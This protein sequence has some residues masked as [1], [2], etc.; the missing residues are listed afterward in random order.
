MTKEERELAKQL[1]EEHLKTFLKKP[2]SK[3][4]YDE[5]CEV[6][7]GIDALKGNKEI[8]LI[9]YR[10]TFYVSLSDMVAEYR[11]AGGIKRLIDKG[12]LQIGNYI[13]NV[14]F[15]RTDKA[16]L[17]GIRFDMKN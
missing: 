13:L 1:E 9:I 16:E 14:S 5:L 3:E 8:G 4:L 10:D 11:G 7:K 15:E 6:I 17:Y 12:S 2:E